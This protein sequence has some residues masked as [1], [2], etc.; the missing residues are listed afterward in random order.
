MNSPTWDL[1]GLGDCDVDIF[2]QVDR[3]PT[4]DEKVPGDLLS[5]QGGG[6]AANFCCA[7]ARLG[8]RTALASTVGDDHFGQIA[9]KSLADFGVDTDGVTIRE[10][11]LTY[12][13]TAYLD[14]QGEKALTI[15][16]TPTFFPR[17]EDL[18]LDLLS[19]TRVLHLA[20]FDLDVSAKAAALA[21]SAGAIISVDLE[22]AMVEGG[23]DPALPLLRLTD[24][25]II[26]DLT[27]VA[28][29]AKGAHR[30]AA[31]HFIELGPELVV[32]TRGSQGSYTLFK[33]QVIEIDAFRVDTVDTTGAGDCFNA[34]FWASRLKGTQLEEA[35]RFASAAAALSV[36]VVGARDGLP[37]WT[38]VNAF[39]DSRGGQ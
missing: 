22:P 13:C 32:V 23:L 36:Q 26:N 2:V 37:T 5:I 31:S 35:L 34:A 14:E 38:E 8:L 16:R 3:L 20:P 19:N 12:F 1:V 30:E 9:L 39:L 27:V 25:L 24:I 18:D 7:A 21:A 15:V 6:V 33:D 29:F 11:E 10:N 28:L 17:W 4:W